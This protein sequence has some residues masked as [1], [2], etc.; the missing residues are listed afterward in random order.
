MVAIGKSKALSFKGGEFLRHRLVLS[1]LSL[2]PVAI[3][4]IRQEDAETPGLSPSEI[5]FIR[6]I[7]KLTSGTIIRINETGTS[8][9]YKPGI[10]VGG[11]R[12]VHECHV[13]RSISYYLEPLLMLAPFFKRAINVTL[14]GSTH[15]PT[16]V[17]IDTISAVS[18]PLLRRLTLGASLSPHL[19]VKK[20]AVS[21]EG[22]NGN[23]TGGLVQF[24]CDV[25]TSKLKPIDL[26][27]PGF[28]KRIR[29]IVFANRVSPGHITRIVS[30]VRNVFNRFSP[31]VY[32]HSDHNNRDACGIGFG[33]HLVAETTEGCLCG[34]D[35]TSSSK[36]VTPEQV[37]ENACSMLLEEI[38]NGG[39]VDTNN[40]CLALL[41]CAVADSDLSR[42]RIG[43]LNNAGVQFMRDLLAFTGVQFKVRVC[44]AQEAGSESDSDDSGDSDTAGGVLLSC[45]GMGLSNVARQRF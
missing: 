25:L 45:I 41:Y 44:A 31:D 5:C 14:R 34:A 4:G 39:C 8:L 3:E 18:I 43:R 1:T 35:W 9:F 28:V 24:R 17:C 42:V 40:G 22:M 23:G 20:R 19:E 11:D 36:D 26:I 33:V 21:S 27:E 37:A 16:D 10:L 30:V 2:R 7:D 15:S 38:N 12:V 13:S 29:G 32:V 6:L